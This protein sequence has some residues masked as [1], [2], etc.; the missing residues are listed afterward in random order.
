LAISETRAY[1]EVGGSM[2]EGQAL[3]FIFHSVFFAVG[4]QGFVELF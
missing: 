2:A 1:S 3:R 4:S